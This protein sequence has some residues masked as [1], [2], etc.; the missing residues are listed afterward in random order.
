MTTPADD[1]DGSSDPPCEGVPQPGSTEPE[2]LEEGLAAMSDLELVDEL[3]SAVAGA[4][5]WYGYQLRLVANLWGRP[6][7][8]PPPPPAVTPDGASSPADGGGAGQTLAASGATAAS[9]ILDPPRQPISREDMVIAEIS[10]RLRITEGAAAHLLSRARILTA[11]LVT[12]LDHLCAGSLDESRAGV[13]AD[14]LTPV[15]DWKYRIVRRGG[16]SPEEA[17]RAASQLVQAIEARVLPRAAAQ[18]L[19]QL[20]AAIRRAIKALARPFSEEHRRQRTREREVFCSTHGREEGMAFLGANLPVVEAKACYAELDSRARALRDAGDRR[21]L[22]EL[23][24]DVLVDLVL[25]PA[26][27]RSALPRSV[28]L[29]GRG[30]ARGVRAH[31][32]ITVS[33]ET[34]LG[35][36]DHPAHLHGQGAISA[37]LARAVAMQPGSTWRRL[38]TDPRSGTVL[39][40]GRRTYRPPGALADHVIARAVTCSHPGCGQPAEA[41]DVDHIV[42]YPLGTTS[43]TNLSPRCRRHHRLKTEAG[44]RARAS[45]D[46]EDPAGTVITTS[47]TGHE[48]RVAPPHLRPEDDVDEQEEPPF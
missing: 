2:V 17:E 29:H 19:E 41:C 15:A 12:S 6:V 35:L 9:S 47:P 7:M 45:D 32:Q 26:D 48:Y 22:S 36:T 34:L 11:R 16:G 46:P 25:N 3:A 13:I 21:T 8:N 37:D 43:H 31:V 39:D 42:P 5:M 40:C 20:R 44:W 10:A 24:A 14:A 4:S 38:I 28:R 23:R 1:R 27:P 30:V 18:N 33:A